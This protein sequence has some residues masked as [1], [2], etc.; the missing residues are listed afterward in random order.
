MAHVALQVPNAELQAR[1]AD[2]AA[3]PAA[4]TQPNLLSSH[5]LAQLYRGERDREEG[6][7]TT[8]PAAE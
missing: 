3:S 2:P 8:A 7:R 5:Q 1:R 6:G 4:G